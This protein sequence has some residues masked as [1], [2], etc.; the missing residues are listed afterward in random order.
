MTKQD[1]TIE[2]TETL[3]EISEPEIACTLSHDEY[4]AI[5]TE[6]SSLISKQT[7]LPLEIQSLEKDAASVLKKI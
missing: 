5:K 4:K 7:R 1:D 6:Y 3:I 2:Q